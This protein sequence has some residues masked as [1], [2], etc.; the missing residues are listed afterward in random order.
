MP[1]QTPPQV[2]APESP[3]AV[4]PTGWQK[5]A[6][7]GTID[8][9]P[10]SSPGGHWP[11]QNGCCA[12]PHG[13]E[14]SGTQP[15]YGGKSPTG[16]HVRP[17][18]HGPPHDPGPPL[19]TASG[20]QPQYG[21]RSDT[22][23]QCW[24]AGQLPPHVPGAGPVHVPSGTQ[25]QNGKKSD[26]GVQTSPLA[27]VPPHDGPPASHGAGV[28][29]PPCWH[30]SQQLG[31]LPVQAEPPDGALQRSAERLIAQRVLLRE[32]VRQHVTAPARPHVERAAQRSTWPR[33]A[34]FS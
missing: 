3:Q 33:H 7:P 9:G 24:S 28:T 10:H 14:P 25:P 31:K 22:V 18:G 16:A 32:F 6:E 4:I 19:H 23:S 12:E 2:G 27:Q 34:G 26:V 13:C 1:L 8:E 11:L 30:A 17:D 20:T 29:Q 21:A 5:Q 15:Q